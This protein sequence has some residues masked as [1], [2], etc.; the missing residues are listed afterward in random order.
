MEAKHT[1]GPW[2]V[3]DGQEVHAGNSESRLIAECHAG[4]APERDANATLIAAAPDL[5]AALK[6][7]LALL[8]VVQEAIRDQRDIPA[9]LL[10]AL[11]PGGLN[12]LRA[13]LAKAEG[14]EA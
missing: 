10:D 7:S 2:R 1:P 5:L 6:V 4:H 14:R 8:R 11:P 12:A 9:A 13:V 3:I